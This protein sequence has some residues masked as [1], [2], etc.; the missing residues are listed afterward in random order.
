MNG[1]FLATIR[2]TCLAPEALVTVEIEMMGIQ[3]QEFSA[4]MPERV[5]KQLILG[6]QEL[7]RTGHSTEDGFICD[8]DGNHVGAWSWEPRAESR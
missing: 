8:P 5:L 1:K 4:Q 3:H 7:I 2:F 6:I